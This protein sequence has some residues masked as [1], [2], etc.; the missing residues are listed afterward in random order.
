M[1]G[2]DF[3][4]FTQEKI[5]KAASI[6]NL[7]EDFLKEILEPR[8]V[9][10]FSFPVKMDDGRIEVF[11]GFRSQHNNIL[12]PF[13]GGIRFSSN[14]SKGEVESLSMLMSL[15]CALVD[16][17]FGGAKGGV[18]V[19]PLQLSK[20]ELEEL[21]RAYVR[22]IFPF[23]GSFKDIPAPD[24]N[25]NSQIIAWMVDEYSKLRGEFTP[26]SFTGKP[27]EIYGLK[28]R[29]EATGYG[30]VVILEKIK[31]KFGLNPQKT[32]VAIQG[33]GN[34]G[35]NFAKFAFE[36]GYKI[37]AL[38][39]KTGGIYSP[40]GFEPH[41]VEECRLSKGMISGCYC[42]G[43]VCDRDDG[44]EISNEGLLELDVDVLVPAAVEDVITKEN[45]SKVKAKYIISMANGPI[46]PE[47]EK[48][49]RDSG[50]IVVPDILANSG[51]VIASYFEWALFNKWLLWEKEDTFR[52]IEKQIASSFEEIWR[53][54]QEK[55]ISL[56]ESAFVIALQRISQ[57][58][59]YLR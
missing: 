54:S 41:K 35:S 42:R 24:V 8:R 10:E 2:K 11:K 38:S 26:N 12:G 48:I 53:F 15:K 27:I 39:E 20:R 3:F 9:L 30:G 29:V 14:V 16:L 1:S 13:K 49:L 36:K 25:T 47:A 57:S 50:K 32:T 18:I 58:M 7:K 33:F 37:V 51:G 34:V 21:S 6:L 23:I 55:D 22:E 56:S 45:A 44:Q 17:P 28:G 19:D 31:E 59:R 52:G 43:S 4:L 46:T 5:K 40:E